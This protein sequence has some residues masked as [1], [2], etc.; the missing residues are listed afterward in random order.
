MPMMVGSAGRVGGCQQKGIISGPVGAWR[1]FISRLS[2]LHTRPGFGTT[3][4]PPKGPKPS[5][6]ERKIDVRL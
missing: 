3:S 2:Q 6:T 5:F 4:P 1:S